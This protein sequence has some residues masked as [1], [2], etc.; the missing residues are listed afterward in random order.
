MTYL[1]EWLIQVTYVNQLPN[2]T[3]DDIDNG[4]YSH[5]ITFADVD[6]TKAREKFTAAPRNKFYAECAEAKNAM[7][8]V[9]REN[10]CNKA[11]YST[12]AIG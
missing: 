8:Q 1:G 9:K 11:R 2:V 10:E 3:N 5:P 7:E 6:W 4:N 12:M